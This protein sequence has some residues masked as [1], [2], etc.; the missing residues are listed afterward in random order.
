MAPVIYTDKQFDAAVKEFE[1][2]MRTAKVPLDVR[3]KVMFAFEKVKGKLVKEGA[4]GT[5]QKL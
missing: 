3:Q 2:E 4:N 5:V 1:E